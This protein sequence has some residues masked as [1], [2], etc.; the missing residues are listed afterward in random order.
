MSRP[1]SLVLAAALALAGCAYESAGTT[2]TTTVADDESPPPT[3]PAEIVVADQMIEGSSLVVESVSLPAPGFVVVR[4]DAGGSPGEVIG[5]SELLTTGVI[6]QVPIPFF[7]PLTE[8]TTVH[9]TIHI[10]MDR[11]ERFTYEPPDGFVDEIAARANGEPA[12]TTA[13]LTLL[14]PISPADVFVD[15]QTNNGATVEVASATLPSPGWVAIHAS[16][17]GEP[18]AVLA[19]SDLL[20]AGVTNDL[21]F[22][23]DPPLESTQGVFVA[24]WIDRDGDGVFD[25]EA[26]ADEIGVRADG[27]LALE[28]PVITV[29]ARSPGEV[30]VLDQESDGTVVSIDSL[31]LPS[32]GFVEILTDDEGSPGNRIAVSIP[33]PAGTSE[34]DIDL[35]PAL[36]ETT[37]LWARLWIDFDQD[38]TLSAGDAT[39]LTEPGGDVVQASFEV[40]V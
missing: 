30:F 21:V 19:I 1:I 2:T 13:R 31:R 25:P 14:A 38:G 22:T 5:M 3:S 18:G 7:V 11:D 10:D 34:V 33:L 9:L 40:E 20:T 8:P 16:E 37:I 23:I 26:G 24:V 35:E 27:A 29:L 15:P 39:V 4:M 6:S 36:T 32:P 17:G 28:N 12:T